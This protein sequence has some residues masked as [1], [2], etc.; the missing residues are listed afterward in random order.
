MSILVNTLDLSI[1]SQP[2][3]G[4][5]VRPCV[6]LSRDR[7]QNCKSNLSR[8]SDTQALPAMTHLVLIHGGGAEQQPLL[9][10]FRITP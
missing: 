2:D 6:Y 5:L 7:L 8:P 3:A 10:N 9:M 1:S 4:P